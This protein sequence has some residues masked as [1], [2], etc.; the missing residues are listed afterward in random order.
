[1]LQVHKYLYISL[2]T[3]KNLTEI[4]PTT[5]RTIYNIIHTFTNYQLFG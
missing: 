1:M 2:Y 3:L 5:M 4:E